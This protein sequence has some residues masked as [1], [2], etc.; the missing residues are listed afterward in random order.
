MSSERKLVYG[1][2]L[3][4]T[5][6]AVA[7]VDEYGKAQVITN[8]DNERITPSVVYFESENNVVVGQRAKGNKN[9]R[10]DRV[11]DFVKRQMS[12]A[13]WT[14]DVD[15]RTETPITISAEILRRLAADASRSGEHNV[16]DVVIT[17]PAYFGD[18]ERNR[19]RQAGEIAGLNVIAIISE[20]VAAAINYGLTADTKGQNIIVYDLG[21]GTFDVTVVRIGEDPDKTEIVVAC[22]QGDHQLGGYNWDEKI[23]NYCQEQCNELTGCKVEDLEELGKLQVDA[24]EKKKALTQTNSV[25]FGIYTDGGKAKFDLTREQFD[26]LTSDLLEQ[27]ITLT[28]KVLDEAKKMGVEKIDK[29]LLV[30]GSTRMPQ[31]REKLIAKYGLTYNNPPLP[32]DTLVEFDVDEA[33]AKGASRKGEI[34]VTQDIVEQIQKE[35]GEQ[36]STPS[37]GV[38]EQTAI[39][40]GK[41]IEQ[42]EREVSMYTR[43]VASKSYGIRARIN[44][45]LCVSNLIKKQTPVPFEFTGNY[46]TMG[47]WDSMPLPIYSNDTSDDEAPLGDSTLL[48]EK[49]FPL[50][51]MLPEGTPVDVTFK[52]D[53]QGK[54][55][56]VGKDK[57]HGQV[58]QFDFVPE[59][60]LSK[61]EIQKAAKEIALHKVS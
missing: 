57:L 25:S 22:T 41:T 8:S 4:T 7:Y 54:L 26:A 31:V 40:T 20:P 39:V 16:K 51:N 46:C 38:L 60:A 9:V 47:D 3:G 6:S 56:I 52:L 2:D 58:H 49:E 32:S 11:V 17:C 23:I 28:D 55:T 1:I 36:G 27:T 37:R 44:G 48:I 10:P 61:E 13:T 5:Y 30:G 29:Y 18:F 12:N 43:D 50:Q 53:E 45:V 35:S 33:V 15:G 59:G 21:G 19:T 34:T 24:E 14:F 42:V